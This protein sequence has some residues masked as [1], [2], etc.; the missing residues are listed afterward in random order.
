MVL[1]LIPL[2]IMAGFLESF[3]TRHSEWHMAIKGG[4]ILA[5]LAFI[6]YYFVVYPYR[7]FHLRTEAEDEI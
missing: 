2:F 5:S 7:M 3:V 1:G 6:L 4:I